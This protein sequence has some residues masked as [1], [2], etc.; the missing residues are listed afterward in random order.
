MHTGYYVTSQASRRR[1]RSHSVGHQGG[2]LL[3]Q[4]YLGAVVSYD[5]FELQ[6]FTARAK[7]AQQRFQELGRRVLRTRGALTQ[8]QR[9]RLYQ[10]TVWPCLAYSLVFVGVTTAVY[11]GVI[12]VL[13]ASPRKSDLARFLPYS[14]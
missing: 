3:P 12:S 8:T 7:A 1:S 13:A 4:P 9:V 5:N 2:C 11:K 14:L 6:T 10:A